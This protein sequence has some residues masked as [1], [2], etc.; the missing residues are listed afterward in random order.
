MAKYTGIIELKGTIG[1]INF[2][3]RLGVALS[4]KAGGGFNGQT[5]KTKA[6]MARVRENGTEYGRC[7]KDVQF[8]KRALQ[9]YLATVKDGTLHQRLAS[10]FAKIKN[11]DLIS[12]RGQ[13]NIATALQT[14]QAFALL[15]GY[16]LTASKSF[17]EI[18][19]QPYILDWNNGLQ[20]PNFKLNNILF[21]SG[22]THLELSLGW[23]NIDFAN[24]TQQ[25]NSVSV[26]L[27]KDTTTFSPLC[28]ECPTGNGLNMMV[29]QYAFFQEVNK[30][31]YRLN[32]NDA[33]GIEIG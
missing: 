2:Y 7:M 21:P 6:S 22:A 30:Q 8:F 15:R 10:L 31:R 12:P 16:T 4:R 11:E 29:L 13:R 23:L 14:E 5:I 28:P 25:L 1:E 27:N 17:Q 18:V 26:V 19:Q 24:Q 32:A 9:P 3:K 33:V 20:M